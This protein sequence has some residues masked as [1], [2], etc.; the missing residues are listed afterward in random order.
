VTSPIIDRLVE[1][2]EEAGHGQGGDHSIE[3]GTNIRVTDLTELVELHPR[4]QSRH[5]LGARDQ[6]S[7][8]LHHLVVG[9]ASPPLSRSFGEE[10]NTT[11]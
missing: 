3:G 4:C 9:H 5:R 10:V 6:R 8:H 11:R 2:V 1:T 7:R